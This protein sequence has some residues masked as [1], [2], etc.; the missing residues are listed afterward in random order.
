MKQLSALAHVDPATGEIHAHS[1]P[2]CQDKDTDIRTLEAD[3][4]AT[5]DALT[6]QLRMNKALRKSMEKDRRASASRK[7]IEKLF[8][9]WKEETGHRTC[10]LN[11]KRHDAMEARLNEGYTEEHIRLAII[12]AAHDPWPPSPKYPDPMNEIKTFCQN[13]VFLEDYARRGARWLNRWAHAS[14]FVKVPFT[15]ELHPLELA[16]RRLQEAGLGAVTDRELGMGRATCPCCTRLMKFFPDG[17]RVVFE[18]PQ[19]CKHDVISATVKE[20]LEAK[21]GRAVA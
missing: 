4:E 5:K 20:A 21:R 7:T 15:F 10:I 19:G 12:G 11:D 14:Q 13:G 2:D 9:I 16:E 3:L 18:C 1:C 8:E 17:E 6:K